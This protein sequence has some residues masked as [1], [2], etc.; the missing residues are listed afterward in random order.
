MIEIFSKN[1][2]KYLPTI[3]NIRTSSVLLRNFRKFCSEIVKDLRRYS[4]ISERNCHRKLPC[5]LKKFPFP[6]PFK[7]TEWDGTPVSKWCSAISSSWSAFSENRLPLCSG[8]SN[9]NFPTNSKHP[10]SQFT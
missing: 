2:R 3:G 4:T 9:R 5:H 6:L 1:A 8:H 10:L 7:L